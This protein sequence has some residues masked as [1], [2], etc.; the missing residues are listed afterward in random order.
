MHFR[1]EDLGLMND[2]PPPDPTERRLALLALAAKPTDT[3][4]P[5]PSD[6]ELAGFVEGRRHGEAR[7]AMLAHLNN[8]PSCY[9]HWVAA[10]SYLAS[11]AQTGVEKSSA[12]DAAALAGMTQPLAKGGK[13]WSA[14]GI[15]DQL[16]SLLPS[17][18]VAV[19]TVAVAAAVVYAILLWPGLLMGPQDLNER[20]SSGYA[21][22]IARD[23]SELAR[24]GSTLPLPG[25]E[26]ALG[27]SPSRPAP[28]AQA[29]GAGVWA[30]RIA[31][32]PSNAIS[33]P[34]VFAPPIGR[35]W[36]DTDWAD[37][38]AFGRWTV[39]LWAAANL[40]RP[41]VDWDQHELVREALL[42]RLTERLGFEEE[43]ER[44]VAGLK[45]V[46]PLLAA[47]ALEADDAAR[48]YLRRGLELMMNQLLSG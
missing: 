7:Q 31:L 9:H 11:T 47:V 2:T 5:C 34:E 4:G 42:A 24:I 16:Q 29:F 3:P 40:E 6:E 38:Y 17:W 46:K 33:M 26:T 10:A 45:R 32:M 36:S 15:L 22:L 20:I 48:A 23:A 12:D 37:Y 44:A 35:L 39:L 1:F 25:E 30:G 21:A 18:K 8:C 28:P 27:F 14:S 19:P 43:A 41:A 13:R